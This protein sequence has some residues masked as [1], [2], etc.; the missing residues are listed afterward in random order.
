MS[1]LFAHA[2][3]R[4]L[5][6]PALIGLLLLPLPSPAEVKIGVSDWPGWVAW[7]VAEKNG[8]F[9]KHGAKVKLVWFANYTDSISALSAGQLDGN[10]Q[11]WS[12]TMAPLAKGIPLK[13]ILVNDNSAGN[14]ALMVSPKIKSFADLKGKKI[15]LEQFSVS[16]FL[17]VTALAKNG[18]TQADVEIV[19]LSAGDAAAAFLSGRVDATVVWNPWVNKI[20]LSGKGKALFSSKDIPGLIPDLLVVQEKSL[21]VHRKDFLGMIEAWYDAEKF[22]REHPDQAVKIMSK[23]VGL[24]TDEY[25]IFLPGT[26]FFAEADNLEAFGPPDQSRSLLNV[27]PAISDFLLDNRLME[28]TVD[29]AQGVDGSLIKE[30]ADK[31]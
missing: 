2:L 17:L 12:D 13:A 29:F 31:K 15:A 3:R 14:D 18:M 25:K 20:E 26:K 1:S 22:I 21:A 23:V 10:C 24:K 16:H 30:V 27:A 8:Y 9:K 4:F 7:Y 28:G 19:N 11:T 5:A 6:F